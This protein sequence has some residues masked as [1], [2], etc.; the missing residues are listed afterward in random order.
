M[1]GTDRDR[2][3]SQ[4]AI[5]SYL[6]LFYEGDNAVQIDRAIQDW[7]ANL[8]TSDGGQ[9]MIPLICQGYLREMIVLFNDLNRYNL[10]RL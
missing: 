1:D 5:K 8:T 3:L 7:I 10:A 9:M 2:Q 4:A 6:R